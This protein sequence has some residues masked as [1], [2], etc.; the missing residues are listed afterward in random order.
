MVT[1]GFNPDGMVS[2][3][4]IL[5]KVSGGKSGPE[6]LSDHPNDGRRIDTAL[7]KGAAYKRQFP[8][9]RPFERSVAEVN[10]APAEAKKSQ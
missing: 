5:Q 3:F 4:R 8:A 10:V 7:K 9:Q 2:T 6:W 1:A